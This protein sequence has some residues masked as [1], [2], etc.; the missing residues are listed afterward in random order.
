MP[1]LER[2]ALK[3]EKKKQKIEKFLSKKTATM[4]LSKSKKEYKGGG[5][6]PSLTEGNGISTGR[7]MSSLTQLKKERNM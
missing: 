4:S 6:D 5:Y 3:E 7:R 2:K 1:T